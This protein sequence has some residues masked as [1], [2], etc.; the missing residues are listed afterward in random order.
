VDQVGPMSQLQEEELR[1]KKLVAEFV[2]DKTMTQD[3]LSK[4]GESFAA[5]TDG[6]PANESLFGE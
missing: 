3:V 5:W 6:G 4:Y 1:L 2:L